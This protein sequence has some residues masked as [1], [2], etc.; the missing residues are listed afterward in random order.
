M[1]GWAMLGS[2]IFL[3]AIVASTTA[4]LRGLRECFVGRT[5]A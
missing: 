5:D 4:A 2:R 3:V 1:L